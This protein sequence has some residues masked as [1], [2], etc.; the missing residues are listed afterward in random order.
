MPGCCPEALGQVLSPRQDLQIR[1]RGRPYQR[2]RKIGLVLLIGTGRIGQISP[3]AGAHFQRLQG[4]MD[5]FS[6]RLG[7]KNNF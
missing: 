4:R 7:G 3:V 6:G 5:V 1:F 2:R